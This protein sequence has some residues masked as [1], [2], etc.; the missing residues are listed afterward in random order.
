MRTR[1]RADPL[2][3]IRLN[4]APGRRR[5][6]LAVLDPGRASGTICAISHWIIALSLLSI[7]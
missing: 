4:A 6:S 5:Y 7:W 1:R 2:S 3:A